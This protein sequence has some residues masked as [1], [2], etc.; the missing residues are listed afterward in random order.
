M[1]EG[2]SVATKPNWIEEEYQRRRRGEMETLDESARERHFQKAERATWERLAS[3]IRSDVEEFSRL[4]SPAEFS[5]ISDFE[6]CVRRPPLALV[7]TLDLD[8]HTIRYDYQSEQQRAAA[9][10]GGIFTLRLSRYGRADIYSS[11]ERLNDE[12]A[13][14]MLLEPVLFP[15]A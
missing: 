12:E 5:Q 2:S 7:L 15:E 13:R 10:E 9:P 1:E 3:D 11:D 14:R 4:A 6:V 8:A